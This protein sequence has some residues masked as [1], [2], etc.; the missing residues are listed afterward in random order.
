MNSNRID[1][2]DIESGL[3]IPNVSRADIGAFSIQNHGNMGIGF[4]NILHRPDQRLKPYNALSFVKGGIGFIGTDKIMSGVDDVPVEDKKS[5][6]DRSA[7]FYLCRKL[8]ISGIQA[9]TYKVFLFPAV[10][11]L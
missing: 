8:L 1:A 5:F 9:G 4:L 2:Y 10:F 3:H 7:T 11:Q 6:F